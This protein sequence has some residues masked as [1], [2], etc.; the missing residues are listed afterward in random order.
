MESQA[1]SYNPFCLGMCEWTDCPG[2]LQLDATPRP[3]CPRISAPPS[4]SP[5]VTASS[6]LS[7]HSSLSESK[8]FKFATEEELS[9]FAKGL[10]PENTTR[11]TKWA[12][13]NFSTWIKERNARYPASPVPDDILMCSEPEIINLHLSRFIV[14]T[15]KS[16]GD[17]YPPSTLHQL[18]CGILRRM[19][20]LNPNCPNF[21]DKSDNRFKI[22]QG[23]LDSY[24]HKL[25]SEG[26][27]R[28]VK[29][30]EVIT[31]DEE[32]QLWESGVLNVTTPRGLQNAVFYTIG[33]L[34]CLRGG[35]EHRALKLSQLQR[36]S[37]KYV[38]HENVSKN[39]NGSFKQLHVSSK[40]VPVYSCPEAGQRC[41][42]YLLDLYIS[43]LPQ[44]AKEQDLVYVRPLEKQPHDTSKP[45]YSAV[46]IG[47]HTLQQ[48]VK[49]M[50][51]DAGISG[52]KTNHSLRATGATELFKRGAPEKLIQERTGHRSL[53]ALRTYERSSEEQHKAASTLLSAPSHLSH[54][55]H[56][57]NTSTSTKT[58]AIEIHQA[59]PSTS[60]GVSSMPVSFQNL[61]GCTINII[62]SPN[63]E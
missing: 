36:D 26:I 20:E 62:G 37:D 33:K 16:N 48:M 17:M 24:F 55:S 41:P 13:N 4:N 21:L 53:E 63:L 15:R 18:L 35:K 59:A 7:S 8:R 49:K 5:A 25:H 10:V 19:R 46:P 2:A 57:V 52:H 28:K 23:T 58:Q 38:Y 1:C 43:K 31:T 44:E 51:S 34:F 32:D 54:Y 11:S 42:V 47:N 30:A 9:T 12:M 29:H 40:V 45:W 50:C 27:G 39:R 56:M 14:E 61:Q 22:L 3:T 6:S 60:Q